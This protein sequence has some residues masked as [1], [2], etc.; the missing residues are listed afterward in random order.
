MRRRVWASFLISMG[1]LIA[2]GAP[3][4]A[5]D[6]TVNIG[7]NGL[8]HCLGLYYE[9]S[10]VTV[11]STVV[12]CMA[13]L[14]GGGGGGEG[15]LAGFSRYY[16]RVCSPYATVLTEVCARAWSY[17]HWAPNADCADTTAIDPPAEDC[18]HMH[19][20]GGGSSWP[21]LP[22]SLIM[23]TAS[24]NGHG[25]TKHCSWAHPNVECWVPDWYMAMWVFP[26]GTI[27]CT[28][29]ATVSTYLDGRAK[30]RAFDYCEV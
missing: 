24:V 2:G 20:A 26:S 7:V 21:T 22:S 25:I 3:A 19:A 8:L 27:E 6:G 1:F 4:E 18:F 29:T 16:Q 30:A 23:G 14:A 12:E 15:N 11:Q 5:E 9:T 17:A 28:Q 10:Y 13:K